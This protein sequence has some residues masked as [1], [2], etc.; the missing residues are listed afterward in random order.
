M[1]IK[2]FHQLLTINHKSLVSERGQ[3]SSYIILFIIVVVFAIML[4][5]GGGSLFSGNEPSS[6][7]DTPTPGG[8]SGTPG[9]TG[10]TTPSGPPSEWSVIVTFDGCK[11]GKAP[12]MTGS[13]KVE[14]TTGATVELSSATKTIGSQPFVP[15]SQTYPLTLSNDDGFG[16]AAWKITVSSGAIINKTYNGAATGC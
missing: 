5:G 10:T 1:P 4:A 14:G 9:T 8:T 2:F 7:I 13:V 15:P 11:Q 6:V 12:Y 3:S 16:N